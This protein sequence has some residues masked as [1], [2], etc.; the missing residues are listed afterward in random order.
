MAI[1]GGTNVI[2]TPTLTIAGSKAGMLSGDGRCKTFD[3]SA[4]G[5]VRGEGVGA[6]LLKPLSR[7]LADGDYVYA[8]VRG[9]ATNHGGHAASLTAPN[10]IAQADVIIEAHEAAG[11]DP[12][13]VTYIEA[14]GTGTSLGDPIEVAGLTQAFASSFAAMAAS[15]RRGRIAGS[16]R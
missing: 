8:I 12:A 6:I 16:G 15:R 3:R 7:A 5:Y 13:D 14:H 10:P 11:V 2:L 1:A 4:N 9:T